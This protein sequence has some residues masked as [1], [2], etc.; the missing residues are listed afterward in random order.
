MNINSILAV[1]SFSILTTVTWTLRK[2]VLKNQDVISF[3]V[4]ETF[5]VC[6]AILIGSYFILGH[7]KFIE[8]PTSLSLN[9]FGYMSLLGVLIAG[10][11]Y[12]MRYLIKYED[13]SKLSPMIGGTKTIMVTIVGIFLFGEEITLRKL[14]SIAL[15]VTGLF[16][17]LK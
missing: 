17:F 12:S 6:A 1:L 15:I 16:L 5:F 13:I 3:V 14:I 11:I 8:V 7:K 10:S 4:L 2:T 9:Q